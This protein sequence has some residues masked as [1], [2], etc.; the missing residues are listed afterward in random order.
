LSELSTPAAAALK[1]ADA[2]THKAASP[3]AVRLTAEE[4]EPR[5]VPDDEEAI[6]DRSPSCIP[7]LSG[8]DAMM[9]DVVLLFVSI[10]AELDL[11]ILDAILTSVSNAGAINTPSADGPLKATL[12]VTRCAALL[13][14][15]ACLSSTAESCG[16]GGS[17]SRRGEEL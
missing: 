16:C 12:F 7:S 17:S 4:D 14:G 15:P 8:G 2:P 10:I 1:P 13:G 5:L 6:K 9:A 11:F 3:K